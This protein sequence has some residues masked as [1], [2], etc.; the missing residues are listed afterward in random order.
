[1]SRNDRFPPWFWPACLTLV[2]LSWLPLAMVARWRAVPSTSPR[3][4][5]IQDMDNQEKYKAQDP[6]V[7]FADDRSSRLD[8]AGTVARGE[9]RADRALEE[10]KSGAAWVTVFPIPVTMELMRRGQDRFGIYCAPCHGYSGY[11]NGAVAKRAE[12]LQ[13]GTWVPP[14]SYHTDPVRKQPVG[15]LFGTASHGIR[16]MPGYGSQIGVADRWAIIAYVRALQRSQDATI[17]DVPA[18]ALPGLK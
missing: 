15:Q 17:K 4:H 6:S 2:L 13:E 7:L 1:M 18:D 8:V 10:G 9:L 12:S 16:T 14:T 3:V 11:G 5:P